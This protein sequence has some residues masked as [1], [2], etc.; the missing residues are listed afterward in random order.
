MNRRQGDDDGCNELLDRD[1]T[2]AETKQDQC[3]I[4]DRSIHLSYLLHSRLIYISLSCN[5]TD[6]ERD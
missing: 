3:N 2:A 1:H 5:S 4:R 6:N